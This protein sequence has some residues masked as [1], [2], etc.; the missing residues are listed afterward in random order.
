M[1]LPN[2]LGGES[3]GKEYYVRLALG[4]LLVA[5]GLSFIGLKGLVG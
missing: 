3:V 5:W 2:V 4:Y 1:K